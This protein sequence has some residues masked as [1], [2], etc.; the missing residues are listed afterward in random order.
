VL[1]EQGL[2]LPLLLLA[3][4]LLSLALLQVEK[5]AL[6]LGHVQSL[7]VGAAMACCCAA[8]DTVRLASRRLAR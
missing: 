1:P 4:V 5:P 8:A 7:H 3:L 2:L 6:M